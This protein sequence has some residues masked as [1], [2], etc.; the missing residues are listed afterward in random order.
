MSNKSTKKKRV[1][2]IKIDSGLTIDITSEILNKFKKL[3]A[4]KKP[5]KIQSE[6]IDNIDLSGI[7][8]L[9]AMKKTGTS[10]ETKFQLSFSDN[11]KELIT[12][13]GFGELILE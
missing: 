7:Q 11:A 2:A 5:V 6:I 4:D 12:K 9:F 8:L 10:Q 3:V 13:S 1:T